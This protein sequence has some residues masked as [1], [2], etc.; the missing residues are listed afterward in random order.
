MAIIYSY[1]TVIP[2]END[3]VLGTDVD[4]SGQ[5]TKNFTVK[6]IIDLVTVSGNDLQAVLTN[7]NVATGLDINLTN[8]LFRG[9]GLV[10]T[11]NATIS[12]TTATGFTSITST[13]FTG[14]LQTAVQP[15][16]T[17]LGTLTSLKVGN[18]TPAITSLVTSFTAPGDNLKLATTK[19]IVDYV[20]TNPPGA[21]SLAATL[22]VGNTTGGTDI[23]VSAGD[24]VTFTDTSKIIMG[25]SGDFEIYHGSFGG[26]DQSWIRDL[27]TNDLI[28]DTNGT[29]IA[30]IS[31]GIVNNGKMG[32]FKKDGAVELYYDNNLK[33]ETLTGGAKVTGAFQATGSGTFVNIFNTGYYSDSSGDVGSAGQILSSTG[34]GTNWINDPNPTPYTWIIEADSGAGSPYTVQEGN[35]I[36]FVGVGNVDTAWDNSSKELRISLGGTS[37]SGTGA[38]TQVVYWT[39]A[40]TV[41]GDAG[42]V[43]NDSTNK[44][45]V[46]GVIQGGTLSDGTFSGTAGTYTGGVSITSTTFV[47]ALTGNATTASALASAGAIA[48]TGDTTST[49]GPHTYTS[50]GAVNIPTTIADTTVTG[51]ALTNLPTPTSSAISA[52]DTILAAMAKLQGQITSTTG[53]AYEGTWDASGTGGGSPDLT[54]A[55]RKVN[56]HFYIVSVAG[57]AEPNGGSGTQL[58]PWAVGD[59]CIYV[60]NGSATDEW[61]KLDQS[62]EVLGSGTANKLAKWTATNTLG[63]GLVED[64]GTTV[65]IGNSGNLAV[66]GNTTL[67]DADADTTLIKGPGTADKNFIIHEGLGVG[68]T[69]TY[70]SAG[71]ILSSGGGANSA[72]VWIDNQQGTVTSVAT[73]NGL[74]GGTITTSGT[75]GILT[76]GTSN[77]IEFL[78]NATP[79]TSDLIWFSD[80]NDSNTLRKCTISALEGILGPYL[81]LSGGTM[82]GTGEIRMPDDFKLKVGT[83]GDME[84]Y[85]DSIHSNT[86]IDNQTGDLKIK[87]SSD[88]RDIQFICDDGSGATT[89]YITIDGSQTE[90]IFHKNTRHH[91]SVQAKFGGGGSNGLIIQHNG[92][93]SQITNLNGHLQFTNTA[94][95]KDIT[96]ATDDGSGGDTTYITLDGSDVITKIHKNFRYLDNVKANFGNGDDLQISHDGSDTFI[97]NST[98]SL[99]IGQAAGAIALRP[100]TN[101]NGILIVE[102][103]AVKLYHDNVEKLSTVSFGIS[104]TGDG[105]FSSSIVVG[106]QD[107]LF[108]EN[109]LRFKS[110]GNAFIDH[111]TVGQSIV[112]RTSGSSSMD[113]TALTIK[114]NGQLQANLYGVNNYTGTPTFNLEV[115]SSGNIIE[116]PSLNPG[117]KGGVYTG[118]KSFTGGAAAATLFRLTRGTTG[119]LVFDVYLTSGTSQYSVK[120]FTVAHILNT[121]PTFSKIID[122]GFTTNGDYTVAFVNDGQGVSGDTVKCTIAATTTQDIYYTVVV[123]HGA[124]AVTRHTS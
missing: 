107:S 70:G 102:N 94:N 115:D 28:L 69:P 46:S 90:T 4:A 20:A 29:Q 89:P 76:T 108:A 113:K 114:S 54:Q 81:P 112:F 41:S 14:T 56:G 74:T 79:A 40:Q 110:T 88:D 75:I 71:Q 52:S 36:D 11:A 118:N 95:D 42:M 83:S 26:S 93:D 109:N 48:L 51:K 3:L 82:T 92:T 63:T 53:L 7:G 120:K 49:G 80:V 104:V 2:T 50:G 25:A 116:T 12:G 31:D 13:D 37:I 61:Q 45:T 96:F 1:P 86:F 55:S 18:A 121:T 124:T 33:F 64:N 43:Y 17:S 44:L 73:N 100:V 27:G 30:L 117:G 10:T 91:T 68:T 105:D 19:A 5:P 103:G 24:D 98:G 47:G 60:A 123:G 77:A 23:A 57:D 58:S 66:Q 21:E 59:W 85:H 99:I 87:N 62:N 38:N 78:S 34:S 6:S 8:N 67:G 106:G 39:G 97:L 72:N 101:E 16:V 122:S 9:G 119:A 84:V 22:L 65:T 15:N 111:N 35:T 32:L